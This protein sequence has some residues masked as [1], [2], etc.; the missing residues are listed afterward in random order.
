[1]TKVTRNSK[2][3]VVV[4]TRPNAGLTGEDWNRCVLDEETPM[5]SLTSDTH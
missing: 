3:L 1:M 5:I 2:A 4:G